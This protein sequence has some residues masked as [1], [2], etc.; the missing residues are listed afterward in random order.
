MVLTL[1]SQR[2][3][4]KV[5][6]C[7]DKI[8]RCVFPNFLGICVYPEGVGYAK[9]KF[10]KTLYLDEIIFVVFMCLAMTTQLPGCV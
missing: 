1:E 4:G 3:L 8:S 7:V 10:Y 2:K 5:A 9:A 6:R